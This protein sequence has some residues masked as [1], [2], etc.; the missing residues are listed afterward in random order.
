MGTPTNWQQITGQN[1]VN[2]PPVTG[3][4]PPPTTIDLSG[5]IALLQA[6]EDLLIKLIDA[7]ESSTNTDIVK[8]TAGGTS[9]PLFG[10]PKLVKRA[11]IQNL[12]TDDITLFWV[13]NSQGRPQAITAGVGTVLNAATAA[14]KG[15]G[16]Y[17]AGNVDLSNCSFLA[18]TTGDSL[19]VSEEF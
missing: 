11:L 4:P 6:I 9:Q 19:S 16:T 15:G 2:G 7:G 18:A 5:V 1:P 10:N 12:S 13:N 17:P 14:G 8:C 3:N